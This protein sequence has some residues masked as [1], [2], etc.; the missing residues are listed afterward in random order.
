[1]TR[2]FDCMHAVKRNVY[3]IMQ[4]RDFSFFFTDLKQFF[5]ISVF[6]FA[7]FCEHIDL[8]CSYV[9]DIVKCLGREK[10]KNLHLNSLILPLV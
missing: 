4:E 3:Y 5:Y 2:N 10:E 8:L 9:L 7:I 6:S 1:M